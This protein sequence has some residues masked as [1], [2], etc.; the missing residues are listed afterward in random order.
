MCDQFLDGPGRHGRRDHHHMRITEHARHRGEAL[1]WVEVHA[2]IEHRRVDQVRPDEEQR[3]AV[4][5]R[6]HHRFQPDRCAAAR[7][8]LD[9]HVLAEAG[10][11]VLGDDARGG[12]DR[13]A[14]H[15]RHDHLD[16]AVRIDLRGCRAPAEPEPE[17]QERCRNQSSQNHDGA[18]VGRTGHDGRRSD[19]AIA[20]SI[21]RQS[22]RVRGR[23]DLNSL[24]ERANDPATG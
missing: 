7:L 12:I 14:G 2:R 22:S 17:C 5:R 8:V 20:R 6:G 10:L 4:G 16:E 1:E 15:K 11:D 3:V 21:F 13:R 23:A 19:Q 24:A 9:H 18:P